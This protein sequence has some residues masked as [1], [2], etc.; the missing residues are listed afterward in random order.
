MPVE[1]VG[2]SVTLSANSTGEIKLSFQRDAEI[3]QLIFNSTGRVA[4]TNIELVGKNRY[5]TGEIELDM[6]KE[7]GGNVYTLPE[8]IKYEKGTD[9]LVTFRDL[10]GAENKVYFGVVMRY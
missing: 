3:I 10:S 6:L 8:P 5:I 2:Q 9:I 4:V 1:F 7:N